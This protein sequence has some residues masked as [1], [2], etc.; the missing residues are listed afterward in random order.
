MITRPGQFSKMPMLSAP[1]L[2]FNRVMALPKGAFFLSDSSSP[3]SGWPSILNRRSVLLRQP[4]YPPIS[5]EPAT[6]MRMKSIVW[7]NVITPKEG[8]LDEVIA[9]QTSALKV[10]AGNADG[11]IGTRLH[12]SLEGK[13]LVIMTIFKSVEHHERWTKDE[14]F[15]KHVDGLKPLVERFDAGYYEIIAES[16]RLQD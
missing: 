6:G 16:G 11:V 3:I 5:R 2:A 14:R 8:K 7:I 1:I 12:R 15:L 9:Y 10:F 13:N 4:Q